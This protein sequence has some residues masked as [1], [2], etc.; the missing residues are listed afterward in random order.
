[1]DFVFDFFTTFLQVKAKSK[2]VKEQ[3]A[4][5]VEVSGGL[6][7]Y[8]YAGLMFCGSLVIVYTFLHHHYFTQSLQ[9]LFEERLQVLAKDDADV[10]RSRKTSYER[11]EL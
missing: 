5:H 7:L 6:V 1:M 4:W 10:L 11:D 8:A 2:Q 9:Q 3:T